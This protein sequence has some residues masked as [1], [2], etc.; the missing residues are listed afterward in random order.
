[1]KVP[2]LDLKAQYEPIKKE[3]SKLLLSIADS[4]KFIGG[5]YVRDCE[6]ALA[7]YC[8]SKYVVGCSSGSDA[9]ILSLLAIDIKPGD[10]VITTPFTFFATAGS[11]AILGAIPKFIDVLLATFNCFY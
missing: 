9:L 2:L 6:Q 10:E 7:S 4:Q 8:R 1:M 11:I 5:P 3:I